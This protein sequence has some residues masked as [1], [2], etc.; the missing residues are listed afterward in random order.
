M[1]AAKYAALCAILCGLGNL[2]M[3][4]GYEASVFISESALHSVNGRDPQRI[5]A[6]DGYYG[7]AVSNAFYMLSTLIV[8]GLTNYFR[9]KW[10]LTLSGA[11]FTFYF[12]TFQVLNRYLYFLAC[13]VLGMA[14]STFNVG[15]AG[16][17]TEFSTRQTIERNQAMSWAV[18]C[19][20]V[21]GAGIVNFVVTTVNL[22]EGTAVKYR[23]YSSPEIRYFFAVF[24]LLAVL[25]MAI[26]TF[27][28]NRVVPDNIAASNIRVKSIKK[29]LSVMLSVL[30]EK[31][32]LILVPFYLYVGMFF[33]FWVSIIPT[34]LQFTKALSSNIYIT[35]YLAFA[36]TVGSLIMSFL[37]MKMSKAV[38]NFS[39][40]PQMIIN[41]IL[42]ILIYIFCVCMIPEWSTVRPNDEPSLLIQPSLF[43]VH[44]LAFLFGLA[45]AA[46]YITRNVISSLLLPTRRQQMFGA[47]RFYHGLAA[48]VL[49]FASPALSIYSYVIIMS[50]FLVIATI[51]YLVT[52]KF[53]EGEE[54]KTHEISSRAVRPIFHLTM[55]QIRIWF[56]IPV[57]IVLV[58]STILHVRLLLIV[59]AVQ[60]KGQYK[61][62]FFRLFFVQSLLE[63]LLIYLYLAGQLVVK[64]QPQGGEFLLSTNGG[65]FAKFYYYGT[66][67]YFLH[68]QVWG[69][70]FQS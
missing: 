46:N 13:A 22:D 12:L 19:L 45:D 44:V 59:R 34:A 41:A 2:V 37:T 21:L 58:P 27:L 65:Y 4:T 26:F 30:V 25:G 67:Y 1:S 69:V 35:A 14:S 5:G 32:V 6:H 64:D 48:S 31:R 49:F 55:S 28:P 62:L 29:Q 39:F 51:V 68:V 36:F 66:V 17:L 18:S 60:R 43:P 8:P 16:Y 54:K 63:L 20:S 38:H 11:F 56:W 50:S 23:E 57:G 15:Y 10:I 53:I 61:S 24:A 40:K 47:S 9:C 7:Q 3:Y 33:S 70:V 52:C 42:H